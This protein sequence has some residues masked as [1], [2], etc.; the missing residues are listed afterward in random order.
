[1]KELKVIHKEIAERQKETDKQ[2][3]KTDARFNRQWGKLIES[4]VE[5]K[6][7]QLLKAKQIEVQ[8]TS[9]RIKTSYKK[10]NGELKQKEF[11]ILVL[12]GS[13]FVLVEV[14]TTLKPEDVSYF[15]ESMGDVKKYLP[16]QADKKA[17]GAVAYLTS[18]SEA[19]V[20]AERQGLFVIKATGDSA[21]IINQPGFKPK[22]F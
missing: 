7:V 14:K 18:D 13:E 12:N 4:L 10:E 3:K 11:D 8:Q 22:V 15:L 20:Y 17:Y 16:A 19:H 5:G 6:L 9:E 2:I 21:S 1:M